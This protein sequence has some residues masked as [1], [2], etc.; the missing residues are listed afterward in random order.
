LHAFFLPDNLSPQSMM[1]I[2]SIVAADGWV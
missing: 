2:A 1:K